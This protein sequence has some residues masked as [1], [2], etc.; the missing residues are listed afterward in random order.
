MKDL[1]F[2]IVTVGLIASNAFA[3]TYADTLRS[4]RLPSYVT[5]QFAGNLGF[6]SSGI[7]LRTRA[8]TYDVTLQYGYTPASI[9]G[10]ALHTIS[11]KNAFRLYSLRLS[12]KHMLSFYAGIAL[13]LDVGGRPFFFMPRNMPEDYY[14]FPKSIHLIPLLGIKSGLTPRWLKPLDGLEVF[15]EATTVDAYVWYAFISH[16][17]NLTEIITLSAGINLIL[18]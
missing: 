1:F 9:G 15:V 7:G 16:E 12:K 18:N 5:L 8:G 10:S 11:S 2:F 17:V 3:T 6:F 14:N 4:T 13:S